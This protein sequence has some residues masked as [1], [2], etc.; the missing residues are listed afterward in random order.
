MKKTIYVRVAKYANCRKADYKV[1]A[2]TEP[3]QRPLIGASATVLP[4]VAF[5]L[6]LDIPESAFR[7]AEQ[8][9]ASIQIP[10]EQLE[11]AA[12]VEYPE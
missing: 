3:D 12:K 10:E 6:E 4:T 8:V 1:E 2:K 9:V 5:A 7:S 11:I